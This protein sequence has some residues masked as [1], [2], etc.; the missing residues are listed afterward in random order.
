[1]TMTY[2]SNLHLLLIIALLFFSAILVRF[3]PFWVK[4]WFERPGVIKQV[5][6]ILPSIIMF[7][8]IFHNLE[9]VVWVE[10]PYGIPEVIALSCAAVLYLWRKNLL[11]ALV[12]STGLYLA[13]VNYLI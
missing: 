8:L 12:V 13:I 5:G 4:S 10:A 2:A 1:M 6:A 9:N 7:L 11:L 3:F